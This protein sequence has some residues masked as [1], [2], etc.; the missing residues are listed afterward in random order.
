MRITVNRSGLKVLDTTFEV[1]T[2]YVGSQG[3]C[4]VSLK[5]DTRVAPMH[6][7][8]FK[9]E[10][11]GENRWF[12]EPLHDQFHTTYLDGH[13]LRGRAEI[14]DGSEIKIGDYTITVFR[15]EDIEKKKDDQLVPVEVV[16]KGHIDLDAT[17]GLTNE[18]MGLPEDVI[19]K[20]RSETVSLSK[21]KLD[22]IS[23]FA[24]KLMQINDVRGLIDTAA[25]VLVKDFQ[26][27]VCWIGLRSDDEG[28]LH[29]C[30]GKDAMGNTIDV[31]SSARQFSYAVVECG[32]GVLKQPPA[33]A[34]NSSAIA[35]PL[36]GPDGS[37]GMI[38]LE[39]RADKSRYNVSDLDTLIYI[40][41]QMGLILDNLL[42]RQTEQ[43]EKLRD[44][45][46]QFAKKLRS[47]IAPWQIP[48]WPGLQIGVLSDEGQG[49]PTDFYDIV[50]VGE[51]LAGILVGKLPEN[52]QDSAICIA[53][54]SSAFKIGIVHRDTPQMLMRQINWLL[55]C[56]SSEPRYVSMAI[57]NIDPR[58]GEF[59]ISTAGAVFSYLVSGLGEAK[60]LQTPN[61]PL[62]GQAKKAKY[63]MIKGVLQPD[64][65]L[66]LFTPGV[67]NIRS[68]RGESITE[69]GILDTIA[70]S[71]APTA[72]GVVNELADYIRGFVGEE[73]PL[74]DTTIVIIRKL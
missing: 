21:G 45:D 62:V 48:Q 49:I 19:V 11:N 15:E 7:M 65:Y 23:A 54:I 22:Y 9:E 12:V 36:I 40:C 50:P 31:P 69:K 55:F 51:E 17:L 5:A 2:I 18:Q 13:L 64:Q 39:S 6:L 67:L 10:V 24:I 26:A 47:N 74:E 27:R 29:L 20:H 43:L 57:A 58:S 35:A 73:P 63:E 1:N 42:R 60:L 44:I 61:N 28:N 34:H 3:S 37:L 56:S 71:T 68:L 33:D 16:A 72:G 52:I 30:V 53:Q 25:T 66:V 41:Y 14:K 46:Q 59:Y 70:D 8:I 4:Q 38:Y 32:R